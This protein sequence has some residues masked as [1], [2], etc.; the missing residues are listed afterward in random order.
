MSNR[1]GEKNR[2]KADEDYQLV[3][4]C[5]KGDI[6][7]FEALVEKHQKKMLN[8][9]YRMIGNYEEACEVV[10]DAFLAAYR[11]IKKLKL[12]LESKM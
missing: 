4:L 9:A 1:M 10:Q 8:I 11:A 7:D 5:Q 2:A 3:C 6:D 12:R